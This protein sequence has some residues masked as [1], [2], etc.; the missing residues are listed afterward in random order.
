[1]LLISQN[2]DRKPPTLLSQFTLHQ[3][4]PSALPCVPAHLY[5]LPKPDSAS[6]TLVASNPLMSLEL[7]LLKFFGGQSSG[8]QL[9]ATCV[10]RVPEEETAIVRF[11]RTPEGKGVGVVRTHG[12]ESWSVVDH[13][14]R[15]NRAMRW[16]EADLV[17]V[18]AQGQNFATFSLLSSL[19]LY[20]RAE[21]RNVLCIGRHTNLTF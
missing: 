11:V 8:L 16:S 2:I 18:L 3:S 7:D 17:V 15:C 1:M 20:G 14:K 4:L 12:G 6:I 19:S 13:G 9:R 5:L 10:D 21:F